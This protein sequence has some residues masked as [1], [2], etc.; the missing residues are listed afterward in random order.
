MVES[1]GK[2]WSIPS[3]CMNYLLYSMY[4]FTNTSTGKV[5]SITK[6]WSIPSPCMN[7]YYC[8]YVCI[9]HN[10][11]S[12]MEQQQQQQLNISKGNILYKLYKVV[13]ICAFRPQIKTNKKQLQQIHAGKSHSHFSISITCQHSIQPIV[14]AL[15]SDIDIKHCKGQHTQCMHHRCPH[16][17]GKGLLVTPL[18][19]Q[20]SSLSAS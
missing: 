12:V 5:E 11:G 15:C 7:Y 16:Y 14:C 18:N 17:E 9:Y 8:M 2:S 3:P 6:S 13:S 20:A 10:N 19:V 1:I 4:V